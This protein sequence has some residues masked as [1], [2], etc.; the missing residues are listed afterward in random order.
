[1][2]HVDD[3]WIY[4]GQ[5]GPDPWEGN[6]TE[7]TYGDCTGDYMKTNQWFSSQG[8]NTD[9]ST[10]Y[11]SYTD[12]SPLYASDIESY[13]LDIYDGPYGLKQFYESRGYTVTDMYNQKIKGQGSNPDLGFTYDQYCSEIDAG[14]PVMIHV[15]GHTMVGFGYDTSSNLMY[16]HDTWDYSTYTMTWGGSYAAMQHVA[17]SIVSLESMSG[18]K[19][20]FGGDGQGDILWRHYG[21]G[22]NVV[23]YM[24]VTAGGMTGL[25]LENFGIIDMNQ[26]LEQDKIYK[27]PMEA[28]GFIYRGDAR[29]Y[30]SPIEAAGLVYQI[31]PPEFDWNKLWDSEEIQVLK[32]PGDVEDGKLRIQGLMVTGR[33]NLCSL[34][35]SS[36][37]IGGT[38]DFNGDGKVDI[39]WRKEDSGKN[40]VWYMDGVSVTGAANLCTV[41][42]DGWYIV[43]TGDFNGDGK[44]DI[45]WRNYNEGSRWYGK[46]AVWY[47]D[48]VTVTGAAYLC[49]AAGSWRPGGTGDFNGDGKVDILW[50]NYANGKNVVWY[51][52]GVSVTGSANLCTVANTNWNID[53]I[54]DFNGDGKVDILWRNYTNGRN[55]VWYMNDVSITGS[56]NLCAVGDTNWN[57]E[58]H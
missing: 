29:V 39:V 21:N 13:G 18:V 44:V 16:I 9:G 12:G 50:R 55:A 45:L 14:R 58:N 56:A 25:N 33:A 7:H 32:D 22:K 24:G 46:N 3:Y 36:W 49:G 2:G 20:D 40:V 35:P 47:M 23:W 54:G 1:M 17:V 6:W 41:A 4:Y 34:M 37:Y 19:N 38:G 26:D 48:G 27:D 57:I 42:S 43:G 52:D 53:G 10:V 28:A 51:M 11:Y 15:V 31:E 8:F 30:W 5:P